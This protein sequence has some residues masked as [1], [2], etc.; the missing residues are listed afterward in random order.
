MVLG[1]IILILTIKWKSD[2]QWN[3][4][5]DFVIG[6]WFER[7]NQ[8]LV[9][10]KHQQERVGSNNEE[11]WM[12]KQKRKGQKRKRTK[13]KDKIEKWRASQQTIVL[14]DLNH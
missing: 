2:D 3:I 11:K 10:Y 4:S 13:G 1:I 6:G 5:K 7:T 14:Y 9:N 12:N 8:M